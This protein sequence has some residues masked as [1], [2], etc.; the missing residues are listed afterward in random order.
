MGIHTRCSTF[1]GGNS[2]VE[3]LADG[4]PDDR[5]PSL[6]ISM[7]ARKKMLSSSYYY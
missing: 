3:L 7:P 1:I 6:V 2:E 4:P 5:F